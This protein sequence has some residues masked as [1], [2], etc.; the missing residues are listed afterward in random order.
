LG[1]EIIMNDEVLKYT[2]YR[3]RLIHVLAM[4]M[5]LVR[6]LLSLVTVLKCFYE[7]Q[8]SLGVNKLLHLII[9]LLNSSF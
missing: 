1:L 7:I 5:I 4:L 3:P 6:Y 8:S 9:V 2:G